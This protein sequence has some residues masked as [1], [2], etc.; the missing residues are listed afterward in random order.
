MTIFTNRIYLVILSHWENVQH[1]Y[2]VNENRDSIKEERDH[3]QK[4]RTLSKY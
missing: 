2:K 4:K 1:H 3:T